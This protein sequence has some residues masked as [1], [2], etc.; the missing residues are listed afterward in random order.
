ME[1]IA[2]SADALKAIGTATS[3]E[4]IIAASRAEASRQ[5][6]EATA[7]AT[8]KAEADKKAAEQT[9]AAEAEKT[10][11]RVEVINGR[12][13]TFEGAN[14]AEVDQMIINAYRVVGAVVPP[15]E[16]AAPAA[17]VEQPK[18]KTAAEIEAERAELELKWK[19]GEISVNDY[20]QKSGAVETY[21][22][23]QGIPVSGLK[24]AVAQTEAQRY[25]QSWADAGA[26]FLKIANAQ[27]WPGGERNRHLLEMKLAAL[28]LTDAPDKLE[29][30]KTAV[31]SL[32]DEG[33]IFPGETNATTTTTTS[34]ATA[35]A[36]PAA[37]A[38]APAATATAV[39][40]RPAAA[41]AAAPAT[42][43]ASSGLF[44]MSSGTSDNNNPDK[45]DQKPK[46]VE[47][48]AT[49]RPEEI[50]N[51]WKEE[52]TRTGQ[53]PNAAFVQQFSRR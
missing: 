35:T 31:Q 28:G 48:P 25:T 11:T 2:L 40:S 34:T 26:Q 45:G 41:P 46:A 4:E 36:A 5:E 23:S 47:I 22:E 12:E 8:A 44:G 39:T 14:D 29:A 10:V 7:A 19:R 53:D 6:T 38:T 20:L 17:T 18:Q 27:Y 33:L 16:V 32:H 30:I 51:A 49:A 13:F 9:A 43:R 50:L 42:T 52:M 15:A 1:N 21:L 24:A 37:A 3:M